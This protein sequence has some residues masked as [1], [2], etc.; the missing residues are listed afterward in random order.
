MDPPTDAGERELL[1]GFLDF[2]RG[3][4]LWKVSGLTGPQLV[5]HS[6]DGSSLSLIGLVRHLTEVEKYWFHRALAQ[7]PAPSTFW[8]AE[9]PDGDFDLVDPAEAAHDLAHFRETVQTSDEI[10][11][12]YDL[13]HTFS[14]PGH[15]GAHSVRYLYIHMIQ[16]YARHN[17][18]ADFLRE[19]VDGL[20]GE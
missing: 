10:A 7:L 2:H 18:H 14:R 3:T 11:A 4:L 20:T 19:E 15:E 17:G 1:Q 8:T 12:R 9:H 13:D 16:E 6:V 5:Q